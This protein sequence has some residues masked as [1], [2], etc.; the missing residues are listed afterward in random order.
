MVK[1]YIR[2]HGFQNHGVVAAP[3][4]KLSYIVL[5][6]CENYHS[7]PFCVETIISITCC[8]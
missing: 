2:M 7:F 4:S 8:I 1:N 3:F 5:W 6:Q